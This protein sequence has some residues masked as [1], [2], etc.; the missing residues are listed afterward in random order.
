MGGE[1]LRVHLQE[2]AKYPSGR[3]I[4]AH[5]TKGDLIFLLVGLYGPN[6]DDPQLYQCLSSKLAVWGGFPQI[7]AGDFNC[8]LDLTV[9]R[10]SGLPRKPS[11]AAQT[12]TT[13]AADTGLVDIW[14]HKFP[15]EGG[16]THYSAVN[17][18]HTCIDYWLVDPEPTYIVPDP[19]HIQTMNQC[20]T[21]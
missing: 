7:W 10:S 12:R 18:L 8:V 19:G 2:L 6:Y 17:D 21:H 5:C 1:G 3:Y 11:A 14:R 4:I 9:D 13:M 16:Y 20:S 15:M